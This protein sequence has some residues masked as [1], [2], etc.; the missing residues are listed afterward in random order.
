MLNLKLDRLKAALL[1]SPQHCL[2]KLHQLLPRLA[3]TAYNSFMNKVSDYRE[4][5]GQQPSSPEDF[6]AHLQLVAEVE[7]QRPAMDKQ[8]DAVSDSAAV[9][10]CAE[11]TVSFACC[12]QGSM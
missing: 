11:W 12:M 8:F 5:L 7:A 9:A 3:A 6:V 4:H 2:S 1:P 10:S